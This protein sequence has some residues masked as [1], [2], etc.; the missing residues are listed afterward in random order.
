MVHILIIEVNNGKYI[1][2]I[3]L[4]IKKLLKNTCLYY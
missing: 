1:N 2:D 4:N 3:Y